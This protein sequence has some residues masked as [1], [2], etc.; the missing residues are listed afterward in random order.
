MR[1]VV[2]A[3]PMV[4][5]VSK[6]RK[7]TRVLPRRI[8]D[9]LWVPLSYS[10]M[11]IKCPTILLKNVLYRNVLYTSYCSSQEWYQIFGFVHYFLAT[12]STNYEPP[13]PTVY[14]AEMYM[15]VHNG[16]FILINNDRARPIAL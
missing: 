10:A 3:I 7:M 14:L 1:I 15:N 13:W 8:S 2:Q 6:W 5:L 11:K 4:Y 9:E 12:S 16:S